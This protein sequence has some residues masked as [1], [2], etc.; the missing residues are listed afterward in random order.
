MEEISVKVTKYADR[1]NLVMYY[2]DPVTEKLVTRSAD[3]SNAKDAA[4]AAGKWEDELRAGRYQSSKGL[5]WAQFRERYE[6]E[7]GVTLS[8]HAQASAAAVFNHLETLVAPKK[9]ASL[10]APLLSKFQ[11][12]LRNY[13]RKGPDETLLALTETSIGAYLAHLKA[14]LGWAVKMKLLREVPQIEMPQQAK[15]RTMMRGRPITG[16][17]FDR[18]IAAVP[19]VRPHDAPAWEHLLRGLWL[20]G[21][22]IE[23]STIVSWDQDAAF[24]VDLSGRRPRFRI[25]AEAHKGRRDQ[26]LPM[27]PD[28]ADFILTTPEAERHGS[29]FKV[30]GRTTGK[31]MSLKRIGRTIG[32]IGE[33]AGA[34]VNKE[35]GKFA[36]AHDLRRSFGSR[37]ARRVA[38]AILQQLM[39]HRAIE[40]TMKY[41]VDLDADDVA[42][43]LWRDH[44]PINKS[45]NTAL[46]EAP[47]RS[48][49]SSDESPQV[50]SSQGA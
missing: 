23:E 43:V 35:A 3:T 39:R 12:E 8:A 30:A 37:W 11:T 34:V 45:F 2:R 16:E 24:S 48:E 20:S 29:V 15:G 28:F 49:T 4:K 46:D 26:F 47:E 1:D 41:Y 6:Q 50:Q 31:Q 40:T 18:M 33:K 21:L 17:E 22:R 38:P 5:T 25:Y 13:R 44:G 42:D 36:T 14:A 7:K 9:L 19:A 10:T 27:T 32:T